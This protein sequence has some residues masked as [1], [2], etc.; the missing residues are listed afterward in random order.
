M[1]ERTLPE[2]AE[3]NRRLPFPLILE[4]YDVAQHFVLFLE[5]G[6]LMQTSPEI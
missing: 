6:F 2:R 4:C 5:Y 3:P 1:M